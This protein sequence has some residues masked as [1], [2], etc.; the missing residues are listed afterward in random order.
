MR[1]SARAE[2]A[3]SRIDKATDRVLSAL[4]K[5][6]GRPKK[7][8]VA[9]AIERARRDAILDEMNAGYAALKADPA[10]WRDELAERN[11]WGST[12]LDGLKDE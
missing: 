3:N 12:N 9:R 5:E 8:I 1:A 11:S 6:T 4:A 2:D 10:A 7:E